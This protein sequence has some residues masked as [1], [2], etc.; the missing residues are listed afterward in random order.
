MEPDASDRLLEQTEAGSRTAGV[1]SG[2]KDR[3]AQA[4][5]GCSFDCIWQEI[6]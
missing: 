4:T 1:S 5:P 6:R 2:Q 3:D